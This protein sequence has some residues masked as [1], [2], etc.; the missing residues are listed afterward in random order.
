MGMAALAY[1]L[2]SG[3]APYTVTTLSLGLF[4]SQL[5][6]TY[7]AYVPYAGPS[8][9]DPI[10]TRHGATNPNHRHINGTTIFDHSLT[11]LFFPSEPTGRHGT[12]SP[13]WRERDVPEPSGNLEHILKLIRK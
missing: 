3:L 13:P 7:R 5:Q 4:C 12:L 9:R 2:P 1:P 10:H 8:G 11:I 6:A